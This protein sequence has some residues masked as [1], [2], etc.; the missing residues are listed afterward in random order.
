MP[1]ESRLP[2]G[3]A[4]ATKLP[5]G[6][7]A[8]GSVQV[9]LFATALDAVGE[10]SLRVEIAEGETIAT[11]LDRIG[12]AYPALA[13]LRASLLVAI[14]YEYVGAD[15]PLAGGEEVALIPPVSGG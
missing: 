9:R 4:H 15:T 5:A 1:L 3:G 11:L 6:V 12:A 10:P 8:V 2:G 14:N 13:A 7:S